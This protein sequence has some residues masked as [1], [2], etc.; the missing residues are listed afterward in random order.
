MLLAVLAWTVVR[1]L[2]EG[3]VWAVL[4]GVL[5]DL[6][7]TTPFGLS[8]LLFTVAALLVGSA[9]LL[10]VG[11]SLVLAIIAAFVGTFIVYG[12]M[13]ALAQALGRPIHWTQSMQS[14]VLPNAVANAIVMAVVYVV[15]AWLARRL[16]GEGQ[17][18]W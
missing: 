18:R 2:P 17:L 7:A 10:L 11:G 14:I 9:R 12:P 6:Y 5:I 3:L 4:G 16:S 1:G 15:L 13:L 8:A